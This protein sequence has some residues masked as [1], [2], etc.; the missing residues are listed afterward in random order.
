MVG[1]IWPCTRHTSLLVLQKFGMVDDNSVFVC[2]GEDNLVYLFHRLARHT[3]SLGVSTSASDNQVI[4]IQ[5]DVTPRGANYVTVPEAFFNTVDVADVPTTEIITMGFADDPACQQLPS[6]PEG[7]RFSTRRAMLVPPPYV[8]ALFTGWAG[9][10]ISPRFLWSIAER[11]Q[12]HSTHSAS[13]RA[14]VDWCRVVASGGAGHDNPLRS[15]TKT[16]FPAVTLVDAS[17]EKGRAV[18]VQVDFPP[19]STV[20]SVPMQPLVVDMIDSHLQR[21]GS[22]NYPATDSLVMRYQLRMVVAAAFGTCALILLI[23]TASTRS[24]LPIYVYRRKSDSREPGGGCD[25]SRD[26]LVG[27]F[28]PHDWFGK[29]DDPYNKLGNEY[30]SMKTAGRFFLSVALVTGLISVGLMWKTVWQLCMM[31]ASEPTHGTSSKE[32]ARSWSAATIAAVL[33]AITGALVLLLFRADDC[34]PVEFSAGSQLDEFTTLFVL[35]RGCR[36]ESGCYFLI[37][38]VLLWIF[39]VAL[40]RRVAPMYLVNNDVAA[41]SEGDVVVDSPEILEQ[42][43]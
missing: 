24:F 9:G 3:S 39:L 10:P 21:Q 4:A 40:R 35:P 2:L 19:Q 23:K 8:S 38:S 12:N 7:D 36:A 1:T 25:L 14:F 42:R 33:C 32:L 37:A 17:L 41:D 13:C 29:W 15:T 22:G 34:S 31:P 11:I 43:V 6:Q 27:V 26:F 28:Y 30:D 5:G 20:A 16:G 18:L